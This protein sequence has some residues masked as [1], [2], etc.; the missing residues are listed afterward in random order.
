MYAA[1]NKKKKSVCLVCAC[2]YSSVGL[3]LG[4]TLHDREITFS[5]RATPHSIASSGVFLQQKP[6]MSEVKPECV[7]F[8]KVTHSSEMF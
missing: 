7:H 4:S 2:R 8:S 5:P 1:K 3:L 6:M